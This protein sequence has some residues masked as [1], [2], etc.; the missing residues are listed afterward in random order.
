MR[1]IFPY[2]LLNFAV[3]AV[4][5]LLVLLIWN[6]THPAPIPVNLVVATPTVI[7]QVQNIPQAISTDEKTMEIKFVVGVGDVNNEQVQLLSISSLPIDLQGWKLVDGNSNEYVFPLMTVF[8]G[9]EVFVHSKNGVNSSIDLYWGSADAIWSSGE[10][11][12][13]YDAS[14]NLRASYKIP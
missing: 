2:L 1:K 10:K 5:M 3:S 13:L 7:V 4:A 11:V 8:P 12:S 9:G 14:G 6:W